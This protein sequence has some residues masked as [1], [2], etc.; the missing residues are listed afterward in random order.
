MVHNSCSSNG[1]FDS[2]SYLHHHS[3]VHRVEKVHA[4]Y[5]GFLHFG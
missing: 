5:I 4:E 3:I 2:S 1:W